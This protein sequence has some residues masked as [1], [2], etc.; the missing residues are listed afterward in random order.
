MISK[1]IQTPA[2]GFLS[3][4]NL[5]NL[6]VLPDSMLD[7]VQGGIDLEQYYLR[8]NLQILA[9]NTATMPVGATP[10]G[11]NSL[12]GGGGLQGNVDWTVPQN[13]T[14]YLDNLTFRTAQLTAGDR[15]FI[16]PGYI[17][18]SNFFATGTERGGV[19]ALQDVVVGFSEGFWLPPGAIPGY[20]YQG[21]MAG[22]RNLIFNARAAV[23]T[24]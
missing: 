18:A 17:L 3:L 8:G 19:V 24:A 7:Q 9:P 2:P 16:T 11:F 23:L 13:Q 14:W 21:T 4:L 10:G 1:P 20:W 5:K 15:I 6:G 22:A 12:N